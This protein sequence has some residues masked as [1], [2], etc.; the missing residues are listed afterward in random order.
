MI[1]GARNADARNLRRS[2]DPESVK[3]QALSVDK[4]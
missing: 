1:P 2:G 4:V 3:Y